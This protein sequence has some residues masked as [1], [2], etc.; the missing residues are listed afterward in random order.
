MEIIEV[1]SKTIV[2]KGDTD[3]EYIEILDAT[4]EAI[5][6]VSPDSGVTIKVSFGLKDKNSDEALALKDYL[7][8]KKDYENSKIRS[9]AFNTGVKWKEKEMIDKACKWVKLNINN[10]S[11]T[12]I[13]DLRKELKG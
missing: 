3:D 2:I 6:K 8:T 11:D 12:R 7:A 13:E 4:K 5:C 1:N 9:A 10:V